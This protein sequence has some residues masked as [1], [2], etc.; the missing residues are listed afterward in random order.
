MFHASFIARASSLTSI[1]CA[2]AL[3]AGASACQSTPTKSD[4]AS[5]HAAPDAE[6][7]ANARARRLKRSLDKRGLPSSGP[8]YFAFDAYTLTPESQLRL[9]QI[10]DQLHDDAFAEIVIE[11]HCDDLGSS[12]YNLALGEWRG[13]AA[14]GYLA[15]LGVDKERIH[16][17]SLG[18]E[19]P[20]IDGSTQEARAANR[21]DEFRF[22]VEGA[23][24]A[25]AAPRFR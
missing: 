9:R 23:T 8:L 20:V 25:L 22:Y 1:A 2:L 16:V 6:A 13:N 19:D 17:V 12:A 4:T 11:G 21:R 18:E 24:A 5:L 10:A 14:A 15:S 7:L 3:V